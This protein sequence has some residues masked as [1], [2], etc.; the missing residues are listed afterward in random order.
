MVMRMN[1]AMVFGAAALMLLA[2]C[3]SDGE[4]RKHGTAKRAMGI[5]PQAEYP[6]L[7]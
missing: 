3:A 2:G 4:A 7:E 1:T 6:V 5:A